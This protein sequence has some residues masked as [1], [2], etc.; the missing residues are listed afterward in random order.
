MSPL[1][2]LGHLEA[3]NARL[4]RDNAQL[5]HDKHQALAERDQAR[6]ERDQNRDIACQS[7][8][9]ADKWWRE[10]CRVRQQ[11]DQALGE[12]DR[13]RDI[14]VE[15]EQENAALI[16]TLELLLMLTLMPTEQEAADAP[17]AD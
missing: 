3:E 4:E 1:D 7:E 13:A 17:A 14:A 5:M 15:L 10:E 6:I 9:Q 8:R 12:R 16:G 2:T 11:R